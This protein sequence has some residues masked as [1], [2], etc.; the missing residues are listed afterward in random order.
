[1]A[2]NIVAAASL[3]SLYAYAYNTSSWHR[4]WWWKPGQSWPAGATDVLK[5]AYGTCKQGNPYCFQRLPSW[6][7]EDSTDLLAID[8][9]GTVYLWKFDSKNP[10][11]HAV[12]QA[13]H[14]HQE[15]SRGQIVNNNAWNPVT[16]E[17]KK[18]TASQDS[19]MYRKQNGVKSF[20]LDDDNCDC[21]STLSMGHGM[22]HN[23]HNTKFSKAKVFGVDKLY[24]PGCRG[25]SAVY[26]LT[27][28]FRTAKKLRLD[29]FGGGWRAFW[30]Y[31]KD[32]AWP[33][34]ITDILG[35]PYGS[36][37]ELD[38]YCFQRLPKWLKESD[39]ELLAVDSK[40]TVY[41]WAFNPKNPVS[42][43]A[44]LAFH[45]HRETPYKAALN[46]SPWNPV[47]LKGKL[48]SRTQD[49]FM[50]R[51]QNG[52]K[53]LLLDDDNCDC[54]SSLNL[55]HGMC[56]ASH[57]TSY[58]K[59]NVF[60]VDALYDSGCH[61]PVPSIGLT[62][63]Y[64]TR[65]PDLH[66]YGGK[67]RAFWWWNAGVAWS[68]CESQ[69]AK[70]V[71]EKPYGTCFGGDPFCFQRLPTWLLEDSTTILAR[72]SQNNVYRWKF[73]ASNP[74]AHAAWNAFHD[75]QETA[76]GAV[77]NKQPWNPKVLQGK[78]PAVN[79]DSF[80]YR[81][82]NGV[83]S[84]LLDDDNC[85]CLSTIQLGAT[86]C[87]KNLDRNAR[88]VD[89]LYD[90]ICNLPRPYN[91][92][93]LYF[94]VPEK[95]LMFEGY[96]YRWTA[97]WWWPK[98]GQWPSKATDV[99]EKSYGQC[100]ETDVYCFG[101]L[102]SGI[103]E[104]RTKM[105]A[106]DTEGDVYIWKFSSANPTAHAAWKAFHDHAETNYKKIQNNRVW[107]PK[108]LKGSAPKANQD[109]FMYRSQAGV[110]SLLLDDDN[111]DCYS[112]LSIGHGMCAAGF[113]TSYGPKNRFG[114]DALY[115]SKCNTP[116][117]SIG[118]TLY[119]S[120]T[121]EVSHQMTS[122]KHGGNWLAFW[123]W[124]ADE[125][126][127]AKESDVLAYPYGYCS[128]YSVYCFGRIPSW[129]REDYTEMLAIDSAG[130]EYLWK[131]DSHNDVAHAAWLAFHD[132]LTTPAGKVVNK[133]DGWDPVVLKGKKPKA[134]QDSFMYREQ[135][136]VKSILMDDDNCDCL[137]T[138]N[139]GHGMCNAGHSTSYGPANRFG[140]DALYD[141]RCKAPRPDVGLTL[142][143]RVK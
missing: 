71:L 52:V 14:D 110:K 108:V 122:C 113:S 72:D 121:E 103:K 37:Q 82:T 93:I 132:H 8:S 40:G 90:P 47:V 83:K 11:A 54:D 77:L 96:G 5:H 73:N 106:I 112:S 39:T 123:W 3:T 4:F 35:S 109:S 128:S 119:F 99:L 10:T 41:K 116:R 102:P 97:F 129:A 50:Y 24:D 131:F 69:Q 140:V 139:I 86:V 59:A 67:W 92:L 98:G 142:Y 48:A 136:G 80:L 127:P 7:E 22:C 19:F 51:K 114:V 45:D 88:G 31:R 16:L 42:H 91:G 62:L 75:H 55:G 118:L 12:W 101:R 76:A 107:N 87:S 64:R 115:D 130:N 56:R 120:V 68:A 26:G 28:Y 137:T 58:S 13:L 60:G 125:T 84:V 134:K 30:W 23:G 44:W 38:I 104:D 2:I 18:P 21:L 6:A 138:L 17:G 105:L 141:P 32:I 95:S 15:T 61:G 27:L 100:K 36:C 1:M 49:S 63:Y 85:D 29:D 53:S 133:Q 126:W 25:P 74:T 33:K 143:F 117:P 9:E 124:R 135:N 94:Q 57:S 70:D 111:C 66:S 20:L 65:R 81:S 89:I 79:Q 34:Q 43:A 78:S 46:S